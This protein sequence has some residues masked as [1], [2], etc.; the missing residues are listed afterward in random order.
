MMI[1]PRAPAETQPAPREIRVERRPLPPSGEEILVDGA[2]FGSREGLRFTPN[3]R[4]RRVGLQRE[5]CDW[6]L[7]VDRL[8]QHFDAIYRC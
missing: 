2:V 3:D 4:G 6:P 5:A 7:L 1:P 8:R